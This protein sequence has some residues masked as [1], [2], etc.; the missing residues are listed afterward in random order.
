MELR[1]FKLGSILI[2]SMAMSIT[3]AQAEIG[4]WTSVNAGQTSLNFSTAKAFGASV[5]ET[6]GGANSKLY[7]AWVEQGGA[8]GTVTQVRVSVYNGDD[9]EPAWSRVDS[10]VGGVSRPS[11][12]GINFSPSAAASSPVLAGINGNL[13]AG[14]TES[15]CVRVAKFNGNVSSPDWTFVDGGGA[16]GLNF[17]SSKVAGYISLIGHNGNLI[18]AWN[19][20]GGGRKGAV[21]QVRVKSYNEST[22]AWSWID[23]GSTAGINFDVSRNARQPMLASFNGKIYVGFREQNKSGYW[24]LRVK[25]YAGTSWTGADNNVGLNRITASSAVSPSVTVTASQIC[26]SWAEKGT[27]FQVRASCY[28]GTNDASPQWSFIDGNQGSVGLNYNAQMGGYIPSIESF[29]NKIY[30]TWTEDVAG[31]LNQV[32]AKVYNGSTWAWVDGGAAQSNLHRTVG[33]SADHSYFKSFAGKLYVLVGEGTPR[34]GYVSV[35][36]EN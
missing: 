1:D 22:G 29:N 16:C 7:S 23:G 33:S 8:S 2:V 6:S 24:P 14:W 13:Y 11:A 35:G 31:G 28:D 4:S 19:E 12:Q 5:L 30:V 17:S 26:F 18:A 25:S 9:A 36:T 32:R 27:I 10:S 15:N 3:N 21:D 20:V 34:Q